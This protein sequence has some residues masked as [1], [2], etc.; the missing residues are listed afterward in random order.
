VISLCPA[1]RKWDALG[2]PQPSASFDRFFASLLT[3]PT[4]VGVVSG[5]YWEGLFTFG[6]VL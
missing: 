4:T 2:G 5:V 1:G 3:E 6:G